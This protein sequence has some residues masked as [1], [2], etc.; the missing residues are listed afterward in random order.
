M[1]KLDSIGDIV[2]GV[3]LPAMPMALLRE[4]PS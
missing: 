4:V 2:A 3:V 1:E